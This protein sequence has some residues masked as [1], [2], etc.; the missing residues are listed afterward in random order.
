MKAIC[1]LPRL[2]ARPDAQPRHRGQRGHG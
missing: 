2:R 1:D